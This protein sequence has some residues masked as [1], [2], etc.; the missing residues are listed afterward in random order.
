MIIWRF[1]PGDVARI[2]FAYSPILELI[3]SLIVVRTPSRHT[4]HLPWIQTVRPALVRIELSELFALVPVRGPTADFL[5]PSPTTALPDITE[6]LQ[7]LRQT[8]PDRLVADVAQV[9]R[10]PA[11]I[12]ERIREDPRGAAHRIAD[13]LQECWD[14][15]FSRHWRRIQTL[16]EADIL[17]RSRR[18]AAGGAKEVFEDLHET[19]TWS[20]DQLSV[21]DQ[22]E[23]SGRLSGDGLL[24]APS[25][26]CWPGVR[27]MIEPYQ[28]MICYPARGI[29]TLW[30]T[31]PA[32][33][34]DGLASLVGRTR[35][36]ILIA[37]AQPNSTS[38]LARM[39]SI[40]PGGVSQHLSVL[41]DCG[42]V[43]RSRVGRSVLYH[44][45]RTGDALTA[46][47]HPG[48]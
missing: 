48:E 47:H 37:L 33:A 17:W 3:L 22:F 34:P 38:T 24:L 11:A 18:L 45:T 42:L 6:E 28:P 25:A 1:T 43:A 23:Y 36:Q 7:L 40:T 20:R 32:P 9:A 8:P 21:T 14:A 15:A 39:F 26:M 29:A 31:G 16:L 10:V 35:A 12:A 19:V 46:P 44:R 5:T 27:K 13:T 2:R 4:L 30:E 41:F